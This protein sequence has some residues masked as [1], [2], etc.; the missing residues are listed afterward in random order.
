MTDGEAG[1]GG[2][3]ARPSGQRLVP[4]GSLAVGM[5][6]PVQSQSRIYVEPWEVEAG[7]E[8]LARAAQ[9]CDEAGFLYVGVC[10][11]VAVPREAA[12]KMGAVWYDTVATLAWVAAH[13]SRTRLLS[14]IS[15]LPYRHPL[16]TAK[17][18]ATLDRL[19]GGRALLGVGAGHVEGEFEALDADFGARGAILD[20]SIDAVRAA[21]AD[22][23]PSHDGERFAFS[24]VGIAPRPVQQ[25]LPVWVG[26]SSKAALRRAAERGDG[27]LPQGTRRSDLPDAIGYLQEHRRQVHDRELPV[28]IGANE[29]LY[30][31]DPEWDVSDWCRTGSDDEHVTSL[32][33]LR[34]MGVTNVQVRFRSRDVDELCDQIATFGETVLPHLSA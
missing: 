34:A 6:L 17:A 21:L 19:S 5:Q 22:E 14:H 9:A 26:G 31:G 11:H 23:Y 2:G 8:E 3:P 29:L 18:W 32:L 15:V 20:E 33:E 27:W 24:E 7:P 16:V 28:D 12:R 4:D 10:D 25:H 1:A 13:T 30:V